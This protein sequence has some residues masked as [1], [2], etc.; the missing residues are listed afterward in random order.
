[1]QFFGE[2]LVIRM[3]ETLIDK[4]VGG[5]LKPWSIK[6]EA[7]AALDVRTKELLAIAQAEMDILDI[8][9]G[10]KRLAQNGQLL[11][12]KSEEVRDFL[13]VEVENYEAP[14]N[15]LLFEFL[16]RAERSSACEAMRKE[17]A[18]AKSI[19]YAEKE[20]LADD[21]SPPDGRISDDWLLRWRQCAENV[22]SEELHL[23]WGKVLAGETKSPG[24]F[25]LRTLDFVRNL[26]SDEALLIEK[27]APFVVRNKILLPGV[28]GNAG[29]L[30]ARNGLE[31]YGIELKNL[32]DLELLGVLTGVSNSGLQAYWDSDVENEFLSNITCNEKVFTVRHEEPGRRLNFSSYFLSQVGRELTGL[33]GVKANGAYVLD[34]GFD[35]KRQGFR[36]F[37]SDFKKADDVKIYIFNTEEL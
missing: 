37:L 19:V 9:S 33:A 27:I 34:V 35:M 36:V 5:L 13:S 28:L 17:I 30:G 23:L 15:K 14:E 26:S 25:S 20:L 1:M 29:Y 18:L 7:I 2:Q 24:S 16:E 11:L 4:G 32:L 22:G 10:K 3:W 6:R 12:V 8:R 21:A 31:K